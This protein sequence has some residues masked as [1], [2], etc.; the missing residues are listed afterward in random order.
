MS[1]N[2][3]ISGRYSFLS[4]NRSG[5][6][7]VIN[8][9]TQCRATRRKRLEIVF[10]PTHLGD[11]TARRFPSLFVAVSRI[12]P[13]F[14]SK[15]FHRSV[16]LSSTPHWYATFA[17]QYRGKRTFPIRLRTWTTAHTPVENHSSAARAC[18]RYFCRRLHR[19]RRRRWH[20]F[21]DI[22]TG[23]RKAPCPPPPDIRAYTPR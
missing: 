1:I 8:V 14:K 17:P 20:T 2:F 22:L 9:A 16:A 6:T 21:A 12:R 13:K 15:Y 19:R 3:E 7:C 18:F 4:S 10:R 11:E 5:T 23:S